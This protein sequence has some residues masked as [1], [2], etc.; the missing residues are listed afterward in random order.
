M[1]SITK[2]G[3]YWNIFHMHLP[4]QLYQMSCKTCVVYIIESITSFIVRVVHVY[5]I[6]FEALQSCRVYSVV[7]TCTLSL[8]ASLIALLLPDTHLMQLSDDE[9]TNSQSMYFTQMIK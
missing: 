4:D 6:F 2:K 7:K 3:F 1:G 9:A 5:L 8:K